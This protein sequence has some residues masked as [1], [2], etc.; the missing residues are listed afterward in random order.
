MIAALNANSVDNVKVL[1]ALGAD[2]NLRN[3]KGKTAMDKVKDYLEQS[4]TI[5]FEKEV[6]EIKKLLSQ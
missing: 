4:G 3:E 5:Y 1:L 6:K 2:K